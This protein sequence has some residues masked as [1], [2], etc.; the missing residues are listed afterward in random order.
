MNLSLKEFF[1]FIIQ[2]K[3]IFAPLDEKIEAYFN[4]AGEEVI[5]CAPCGAKIKTKT[6][7]Y[8]KFVELLKDEQ[9][10]KKIL[11][12]SENILHD[13]VILNDLSVI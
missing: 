3:H 11:D 10:L 12:T 9:V 5:G 13:K 7:S 6:D 1:N 2:N 4:S 8:A